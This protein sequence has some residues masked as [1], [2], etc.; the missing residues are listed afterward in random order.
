MASSDTASDAASGSPA[1]SV[2]AEQRFLSLASEA[3]L[4]VRTSEFPQGTRTAA[5]AAAAVGCAVA[6]I[7]KSL[8]FVADGRAVMVLTSGANR[9]DEVRL[10]AALDAADVR[11][12]TAD[13]AR[14]ATGYAIG[15]T[16]PICHTGDGVG[17]VLIDPDLLQHEVVWAAAGT[18][19]S[20]FPI[21]PAR[22]AQLAGARSVPVRSDA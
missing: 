13:E 20:V 8:V 17:V 16:P 4:D 11:K 9:V 14:A 10:A 7:V 19:T 12:A 3:G 21:A 1:R 22:L 18:P 5:E 2:A 6:A 15:G